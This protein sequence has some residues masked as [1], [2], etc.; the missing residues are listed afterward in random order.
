MQQ[1]NCSFQNV[2]YNKEKLAK[3]NYHEYRIIN[4]KKINYKE[5]E[6]S[7]SPF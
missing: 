3:I 2:N 6:L 4:S 7:L 5:G 1:K